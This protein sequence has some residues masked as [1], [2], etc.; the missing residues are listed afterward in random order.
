MSFGVFIGP[1]ESKE[2]RIIISTH[3][4]PVSKN[5]F[6]ESIVVVRTGSDVVRTTLH[7]I[8]Q[9]GITGVGCHEQLH[10]FEVHCELAQIGELVFFVVIRRDKNMIFALKGHTLNIIECFF[11]GR[12][13][14]I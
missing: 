10:M 14:W 12:L 7:E 6:G 3:A 2:I 11:L 9:A 13:V 4:I 5:G 1:S 8:V